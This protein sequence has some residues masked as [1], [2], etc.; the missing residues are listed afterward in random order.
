[1]SSYIKVK[2]LLKWA[3]FLSLSELIEWLSGYTVAIGTCWTLG[4]QENVLLRHPGAFEMHKSQEC[5]WLLDPR[6]K[7]VSHHS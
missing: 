6:S 7:H 3:T 2:P 5:S 1:M 4:G